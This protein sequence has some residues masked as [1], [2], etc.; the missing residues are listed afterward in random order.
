M[1]EL[2]Q[3][4]VQDIAVFS[5]M[6]VAEDTSRFIN[7]YDLEKP[8]A[9]FNKENVIYLSIV[10]ENKLIG[11]VILVLD[12]DGVCVDFRRIVVARKSKGIGHIAIRKMEAFC[13][14]SLHRKR[15]FPTGFFGGRRLTTFYRHQSI[16]FKRIKHLRNVGGRRRT[17]VV[18]SHGGNRGSNPLGS[19]T[20]LT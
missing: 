17:A 19:A 6:E 1:I 11:F 16:N 3:A 15:T 4:L 18:A 12:S 14:E 13:K 5:E 10:D 20:Q 9:E 2:R 8:L 7:P